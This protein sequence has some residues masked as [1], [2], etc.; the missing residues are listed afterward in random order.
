MSGGATDVFTAL[1][2]DLEPE[3]RYILLNAM[4]NQL[5][6]PN[7]HTHYFSCLLLHLFETNTE[8]R[9]PVNGSVWLRGLVLPPHPQTFCGR[10]LSCVCSNPTARFRLQV[11][12]E[13]ITRVLLERLIVHRP[14]PWGLLITFIELIKN[15]RCAL[16]PPPPHTHAHTRTR[17]HTHTHTH[18][19]AHAHTHTSIWHLPLPHRT[20]LP[21]PRL[22]LP[23][24]DFP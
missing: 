6:F 13:A 21:G 9:R 23:C 22:V 16:P 24:A 10:G 3:G 12:K 18:A 1:V 11:V 19:R 15:P 7:N 2:N 5:R 20:P 14:H 17:T 8:V 4:T